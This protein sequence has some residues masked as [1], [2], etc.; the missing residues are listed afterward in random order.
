MECPLDT[1]HCPY[2]GSQDIARGV[3]KELMICRAC[4]ES[5]EIP[6]LEL[7]QLEDRLAR[8]ISGQSIQDWKAKAKRLTTVFH[9][10]WRSTMCYLDPVSS[11]A[12]SHAHDLM[13][14]GM[15]E[16]DAIP[17]VKLARVMLQ[18]VIDADPAL[19]PAPQPDDSAFLDDWF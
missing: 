2:C 19:A 8:A 17:R 15:R 16:D 18:R 14:R 6:P 12:I 11:A 9:R 13:I 5:E 10:R 1:I 3:G 4:G 7:I